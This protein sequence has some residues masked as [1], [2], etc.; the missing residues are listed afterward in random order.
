MFITELIE[1]QYELELPEKFVNLLPEYCP[2]CGAPMSI[3]PTLTGLQCSNPRCS[4]KMVMRI[5]AL[6]N[7]LGI[8]GFGESNIEKFIDTWHPTNPMDIFEWSEMETALLYDG[9]SEKVSDNIRSQIKEKNKMLLWEY[10]MFCNIPNIRT[11]AIKI[12]KGY[13]TLEEAFEDIENPMT[14]GVSFIQDKLGINKEDE[15]SLQAVKVY[16]S[17]MNY[18]EDLIEGI[19]FVN[20][21]D[22]SDVRELNVVCSDQVGHGF[23]KKSEFYAYINNKYAD[24]VHVNF[25]PSVT[26]NIDYLVWAGADGSPARYT[27]KVKTVEGYNAKGCNIPIVTATQFIEIVEGM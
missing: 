18:K 24:K 23:N 14:G 3:S 9:A 4:D 16:E 17:L 20:I 8:L 6:C 2:T 11:S 13:K 12:F 25:L 1:N 15:V 26:K 27:S 21:V 10:V 5:R 19:K 7:D 22:L